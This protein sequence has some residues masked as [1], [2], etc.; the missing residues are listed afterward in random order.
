MLESWI[1]DREFVLTS[2][3]QVA[4]Q[5]LDHLPMERGGLGCIS[6]PD[7]DGICNIW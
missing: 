6:A 7:L 5:V 2:A 4:E 1:V 3:A